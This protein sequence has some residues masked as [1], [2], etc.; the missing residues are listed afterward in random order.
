MHR[1]PKYTYLGTQGI[2]EQHPKSKCQVLKLDKSQNSKT[3]YILEKSSGSKKKNR[4]FPKTPGKTAGLLI[5]GYILG[6]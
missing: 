6:A 4:K 2:T 3:A 5:S 1:N